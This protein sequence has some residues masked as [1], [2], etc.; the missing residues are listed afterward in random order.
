MSLRS[1]HAFF[2]KSNTIINSDQYSTLKPLGDINRYSRSLKVQKIHT[3]PHQKYYTLISRG[4]R[5]MEGR[6][7]FSS[8]GGVI[9]KKHVLRCIWRSISS[10]FIPFCRKKS[11]IFPQRGV[12]SLLRTP[13]LPNLPLALI[14]IDILNNQTKNLNW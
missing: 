11:K 14:P 10:F 13:P 7:D 9:S 4:S 3:I 5:I 12:R 2:T 6:R 8:R 1:A